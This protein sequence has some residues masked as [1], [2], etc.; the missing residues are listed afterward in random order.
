MSTNTSKKELLTSSNFM[1]KLEI[2][3]HSPRETRK[4]ARCLA[5]CVDA[6]SV[7][8]LKGEL[9]TGKTEFV[10]GFADY[11]GI[12]GVRSP[13]FTVIN[14]LEDEETKL[15]HIDFFRIKYS[16]EVFLSGFFDLLEDKEAIK[17]IEWPDVV[18]NFLPSET[19][20]IEIEIIG[21]TKRKIKMELGDEN[22]IKKLKSC[23]PIQ[24]S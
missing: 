21:K 3:T 4:V 13:S 11:F 1:S 18:E 9:G 20:K 6:G 16:E 12:K 14:V 10:R 24:N 17:L 22:I 5:Q 8:I 19:I 15:Y 7:I 23:Y 2:L